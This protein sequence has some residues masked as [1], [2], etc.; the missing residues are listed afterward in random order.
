VAIFTVRSQ[1]T[2]KSIPEKETSWPLFS[3]LS[4]VITYNG[5]LLS[6]NTPHLAKKLKKLP[7]NRGVFVGKKVSVDETTKFDTTKGAIILNDG[8]TVLPFSYL[9][10]PLVIG[11]GSIVSPHSYITKSSIGTVCKVG[12]EVTHAIMQGYSNKAHYGFLGHSYVGEWVNLGGGS[13]TSNLKNTYGTIRMQK[14]DTGEQLLGSV[15]G[16]WSKVSAG[17][18]ISAGKVL[19]VNTIVYG[20]VT[21]D[22]PSFTNYASKDSL[23]ECPLEIAITIAARMRTRRDLTTPTSYADMMSRIYDATREERKKASVI[24]GKLEF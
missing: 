17:A 7:K 12:G 11:A 23:I 18:I 8:V 20:T 24:K 2:E 5:I 16:D 22:V 6:N 19:G 1:P 10:G 4:D 9:V 14:K 13:A 15:I 3:K 21:T